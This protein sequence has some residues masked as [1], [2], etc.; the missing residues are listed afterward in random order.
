MRQTTL[1]VPL[2]VK[3]ESCSRLSALITEFRLG[4]EEQAAGYDLIAVN[5][6]VLHFMSMSVFT[7]RNYDPLFILEA[8]FDGE[9]GVFWGQLEATFGEQLRAMLRCCKKPL[10]DDG[11]L[12]DA[13]TSANSRS[14]VA[15]YFEARTQRP[16]V[17]HHGNRGLT[18][19][20]ILDDGKLFE[21]V[22]GELD[23]ASGK[24]P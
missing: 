18:R 23:P 17:F 20:R 10:D 3:P 11:D 22:R 7:H 4:V 6:P 19:D 2:E 24:S 8:N 5:V 1:C 14:P 21:A 13:V 9:P 16:S 12:F 15:P